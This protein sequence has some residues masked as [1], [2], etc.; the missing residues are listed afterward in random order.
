M[1]DHL[2]RLPQPPWNGLSIYPPAWY[3][4]LVHLRSRL[5]EARG[6]SATL[7]M[8]STRNADQAIAGC[9]RA[10][11]TRLMALALEIVPPR[12]LEELSVDDQAYILGLDVSEVRE[13]LRDTL[14]E[15]GLQ[16]LSAIQI[17]E[18]EAAALDPQG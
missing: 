10:E 18:D 11:A 15:I 16:P 7:G 4:N 2:P 14:R 8:H 13:Y 12:Y 1:S 17:V 6:A 9:E 5:S 3:L